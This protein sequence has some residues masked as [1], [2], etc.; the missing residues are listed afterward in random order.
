MLFCR[1]RLRCLS[2]PLLL[3]LSR[4][5]HQ[6]DGRVLLSV[7]AEIGARVRCVEGASLVAAGRVS[8]LAQVG[9]LTRLLLLRAGVGVG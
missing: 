5:S 9:R 1:V 3:E 7:L 8:L 4:M 6:E 2:E